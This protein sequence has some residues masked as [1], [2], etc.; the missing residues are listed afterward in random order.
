MD[1]KSE[2]TVTREGQF[3][4]SSQDDVDEINIFLGQQNR[5]TFQQVYTKTFKCEYLLQLYPFD[6]QVGTLPVMPVILYKL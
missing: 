1:L 2:V 3:S 4:R 6:T 5:I